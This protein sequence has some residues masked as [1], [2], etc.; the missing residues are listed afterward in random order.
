MNNQ[1]QTMQADNERSLKTL[2]RAILLSQ[3]Q[4]ALI[5]VR[6][7]YAQ[8]RDR[9]TQQLQA[10]V[11]FPISIL[12]LPE[13]AKTLYTTIQTAL[14]TRSPDPNQGTV[15][16]LRVRQPAAPPE[17]AAEANPACLFLF[18]LESLQSL[19]QALI[20][21]NIVREELRRQFQ[22]PIVLWANDEVLRQL[23]RLTPD[24]YSWA[25]NTIIAFELAP[26]EL[27]RSLK[28]HSDRLF[29][30]VLD[31]GDEQVWA[32]QHPIRMANAL[33]TSEL[34]IAITDLTATGYTIDPELQA[35]LDFLV[36]QQAY[37]KGNMLTARE[38]YERSL[39][40]WLHH[41]ATATPPT[42]APSAR[43]TTAI[44]TGPHPLP[45]IPY[46]ERAACVLFYLGLWW[47][48]HAVMERASYTAACQQALYYFQRSLELFTQENRQDLVARFM[49]AQAETLQKLERWD[50]L[51]ALTKQALVLHKLYRDPVRQAR[52]YGFL[53]E[54]AIARQ[55]WAT[56][57]QSTYSALQILRETEAELDVAGEP[58]DPQ[59][60][61]SLELAHRYHCNWYLYLL[62]RAEEHLGNRDAAIL[63]LEAARDR[64]HPQS[65]P[66]LYIQI[67]RHLRDLY[68]EQG[69]YLEAFRT[70]QLRRLIEHQYGYRAFVGAL[71]LQPLGNGDT[72][73]FPPPVAIDPKALLNQEIRASGRQKDLEKLRDR[74]TQAQY[75]LIVLHGPSG[76][77]K[78]SIV[79]AGLVPMLA[80]D[81]VEGRP[82]WPIVVD[83]Y[84]DW[85]TSL[86]RKLTE[87]LKVL[88]ALDPD[89]TAIDFSIFLEPPTLGNGTRDRAPGLTRPAPSQSPTFYAA[90]L[91]NHLRTATERNLLPVLIFDQFEEFF[92]EGTTLQTRR[93]FYYFLQ[94][95]LNQPFV[96]V[97]LT[98]R[99]DYLHY[100]LE[101]QRLTKLDIINNDIL[102]KD[103][104]YPLGDL[105]PEEA[106]AVIKNLTD[107]A[108]FYL[109]DDLIEALVADLAGELGAVRP[110]E[111]QVVGA[112]LQ[113]EG[114]DTLIAYR[115][116]GPKERLVQRFL[117]D[118][119]KD[120]GPENEELARVV[121]YLLTNENG[122]RPLKTQDDL[123][124]DLIDLGLIQSPTTL[125]LVLEVL[126][127]SGL[128][129][130]IPESPAACYQ[131][132]HDYLVSFIRSEQESEITH[133]Q[134]ELERER[135][136][137]QTVE[138]QLQRSEA[139][140]SET[141]QA[142]RLRVRQALWALGTIAI[143]AAIIVLWAFSAARRTIQE[144]KTAEISAALTSSSLTS[145]TCIAQWA[146]AASQTG[147]PPRSLNR[148]T[149]TYTVRLDR[150]Q[151]NRLDPEVWASLQAFAP[152]AALQ[153]APTGNGFNFGRFQTLEGAVLLASYLQD[154]GVT[155]EVV[156]LVE[157]E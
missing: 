155:A 104:R 146:K 98:L 6:C 56:A 107:K 12:T 24:L 45:P 86:E 97:I 113:V 4:F 148:C 13:S 23:E 58:L 55:D 119:V 106:K 130:L 44:A 89:P 28:D 14:A 67:L 39:D 153:A 34:T 25:G 83:V 110:I 125:N 140:L 145:G 60:A 57:K 151:I 136:K 82:F 138:E 72:A 154:N 32:R 139:Q 133:L 149:Y 123:E 101:F 78:S 19:D 142:T 108:Q 33:R 120:C 87:G 26:L 48:S 2:A 61:A 36:G 9:L 124:A 40:F 132:V 88:P 116:K 91:L 141:R 128:V 79:N 131:L 65:D 47:R 68:F 31:M 100:L 112:Q 59:L 11:P 80:A 129:F 63:H 38:C 52:D 75:K 37:A 102:G 74:L 90:T 115:Q 71:R 53:A 21:T 8:L 92:F 111:L 7:N 137:R 73:G 103:I 51:A 3:H 99:E 95:C 49:I 109:P 81:N 118:A 42:P 54:T 114:I 93:P 17:A 66:T 1:V 156:P 30:S 35:S 152:D 64:G 20:A 16:I 41:L 27:V 117:E 76:V 18:G 126:V 62:A 94:D 147:G 46:L 105:A 122:T 10:R 143:A 70:R 150:Q 29:S 5:L 77:G 84:T 50:E 15:P 121:L 127:G 144:A 22:F 43:P 135:Q 157:V 96:K 134:L 85:Q 69:K